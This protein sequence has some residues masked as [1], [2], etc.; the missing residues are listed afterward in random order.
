LNCRSGLG[1]V[2]L[3]HGAPPGGEITQ[4]THLDDGGDI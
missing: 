1:N 2:W 3:T 4:A